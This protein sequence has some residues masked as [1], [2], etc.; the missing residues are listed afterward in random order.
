M[1]LENSG[2]VLFLWIVGMPLIGAI[3]LLFWNP[4]AS[5]TAPRVVS[6]APAPATGDVT[7]RIAASENERRDRV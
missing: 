4:L 5:R 1:S 7:A 2:L 6:R 3:I